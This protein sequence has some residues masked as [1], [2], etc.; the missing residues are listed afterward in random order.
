MLRLGVQVNIFAY[1]T[2]IY[3]ALWYFINQNYADNAWNCICYCSTTKFNHIHFK[4]GAKCSQI[5]SGLN[6]LTHQ[7]HCHFV[8]LRTKSL[9]YSAAKI[10]MIGQLGPTTDKQIDTLSPRQNGRH[11]PDDIF[12]GIFFNENE[13]ISLRISLKIVPYVRINN[14]PA[15]VQ[16]MAWRRPGGK[17]LSGP[18]MVSLL[19]HLCVARPQWVNQDLNI[20]WSGA[21]TGILRRNLVNSIT[22]ETMVLCAGHQQPRYAGYDYLLHFSIT[23][24]N[25]S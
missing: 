7:S 6:D 19:T 5:R 25:S 14:I 2:V 1:N 9:M 4:I 24:V 13:C 10:K 20:N 18:M 22:N 16:I 8:N 3:I 11:F 12:K 21:D 17:P 15:L 23:K